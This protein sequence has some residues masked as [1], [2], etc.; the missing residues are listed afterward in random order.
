MAR[1][2]RRARM[3][4]RSTPSPTADELVVRAAEAI[5]GRAWAEQLLRYYDRMDRAFNAARQ[6]CEAAAGCLVVAQRDGD[7]GEISLAHAALERALDACRTGEAAREQGRRALQAALDALARVDGDG[8]RTD[9]AT[10]DREN[11]GDPVP[12]NAPD[13]TSAPSPTAG[14]ATRVVRRALWRLGR[15][16]VR[17][18]PDPGQSWWWRT[19]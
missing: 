16:R 8:D 14:G 7:P 12:A 19:R 5:V 1:I 3:A 6:R 18:A 2:R 11:D 15:P 13:V 4:Q 17:R 9:S 10:A